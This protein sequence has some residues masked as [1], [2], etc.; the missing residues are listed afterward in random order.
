MSIT[1][2]SLISLEHS[3]IQTNNTSGTYCVKLDNIE[4]FEI[5]D[6]EYPCTLSN[7][8][9]GLFA[10]NSNNIKLHYCEI[11]NMSNFGV[12]IQGESSSTFGE[13]LEVFECNIHDIGHDA[14]IVNYFD[15]IGIENTDIWNSEL[16]IKISGYILS[17]EFSDNINIKNCN[18][19][20][21]TSEWFHGIALANFDMQNCTLTSLGGTFSSVANNPTYNSY[22]KIRDCEFDNITS[23][24]LHDTK[25]LEFKHNK[26][27]DIDC[28]EIST[29]LGKICL[30]A[31]NCGETKLIQNEFESIAT[32]ID[33]TMIRMNHCPNSLISNNNIIST[34]GDEIGVDIHNSNETEVENNF[35]ENPQ[36]GIVLNDDK[37]YIHHN[38]LKNCSITSLEIDSD[39]Y[40]DI[41]HNSIYNE[42]N[43]S[44][45]T[46]VTALTSS[47][48]CTT[49]IKNNIFYLANDLGKLYKFRNYF[50]INTDYNYCNTEFQ[51]FIALS[52]QM[53]ITCHVWGDSLNPQPGD[54]RHTGNGVNSI[55]TSQQFPFNNVVNNDFSLASNA[56]DCINKGVYLEDYNEDFNGSYFPSGCS[57]CTTGIDI[58]AIEYY[59]PSLTSWSQSD[60]PTGWYYATDDI[61]N[62]H[63]H[64]KKGNIYH[65][66][67]LVN[68]RGANLYSLSSTD[69]SFLKLNEWGIDQILSEAIDMG[70]NTI[71]LCYNPDLIK[72]E[73]DLA[74]TSETIPANN[75]TKSKPGNDIFF[76]EN[77]DR[78]TMY[79]ALQAI[80]DRCDYWNLNV[81]LDHHVLE[82]GAGLWYTSTFT[83]IDYLKTLFFV[84]ENF[85]Q[86]N[87]IGID[88]I[89]E[90]TL[91]VW[92]GKGLENDFRRFAQK[93]GKGIRAINPNWLIFVEG[94]QYHGDAAK[95]S[96][97]NNTFSYDPTDQSL[98]PCSNNSPCNWPVSETGSSEQLST[99]GTYPVEHNAIPDYKLVFSPHT[100][101]WQY[102]YVK[103]HFSNQI[104]ADNYEYVTDLNNYRWGYLAEENAVIVGE[105]GAP[106][107]SANGGT[108]PLPMAYS[109]EWFQYFIK[110]MA[111]KKLPGSFYWALN[112]NTGTNIGGS[113]AYYGL[114]TDPNWTVQNSEIVKEYS[115]MFGRVKKPIVSANGGTLYSPRDFTEYTFP[116]NCCTTATNI[117]VEHVSHWTGVSTDSLPKLSG[118]RSVLHEFIIKAKDGTTDLQNTDNPFTIKIGVTENE[119]GNNKSESDINVYKYNE[120]SESWEIFIDYN[121][122]TYLYDNGRQTHDYTFSTSDFGIYALA[123]EWD[124][125]TI[126]L[127]SGWN[128][129]STFIIANEPNIEDMFANIVNDLE[130]IKTF[131]GDVYWP[132]QGVNNIGNWNLI[133][134]YQVLM[135]NANSLTTYGIKCS[136]QYTP[137][138]L[139]VGWSIIAY[140]LD[141]AYD[142]EAVFA[143]IVGNIGVQDGIELVKDVTGKV[144][145]PWFSLNLIGDLLPGQ[146]YQIKMHEEVDFT[147]PILSQGNKSD[148]I[149]YVHKNYTNDIYL[150]PDNFM[151]IGI[152]LQSWDTP[153][154]IGDEIA[155][156]GESG[157]LV[158]KSIFLGNFSA[159]TIHGDD[160]YTPNVIENLAD[161]EEFTIEI[162]SATKNTTKQYKFEHWD[163]GD[164]F[165]ETKQIAIVSQDETEEH[166]D[167]ENF[168]IKVFPNPSDGIMKIAV[169][170]DYDCNASVSIV[171]ILGKTVY[172]S[173]IGIVKGQQDHSLDLSHLPSGSYTLFIAT[174]RV[175]SHETIVINK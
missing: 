145:W 110:Y 141:D 19:H 94:V 57:S 71:R 30:Y 37:G 69:F 117:N 24:Q 15:N 90:P 136:P 22:F 100:Y 11:S 70:I 164:R 132:G 147:Y 74:S 35:I 158:G 168:Q 52:D 41:Y 120:N 14:L 68:I 148:N 47:T 54:Y 101:Q 103:D 58:G 105:F 109:E 161:G 17:L 46:G 130:Q 33:G 96:E 171:D 118:H 123:T 93:A 95:E 175:I 79:E 173:E 59:A 81:L 102:N 134:G 119:L 2:S 12:K 27:T 53:P 111:E 13:N 151:I 156:F 8:E 83:E 167:S 146:G 150:N 66:G 28:E 121:N 124:Q 159:I 89:N 55:G 104:I 16:A 78:I 48:N 9:N 140:L 34:N 133:E 64:H 170:S 108:L 84:A 131:D 72:D 135:N 5:L 154:Q 29:S 20:D 128:M 45:Y 67:E 137:I 80:V 138:H 43:S 86:S 61:V 44:N 126:S 50:L 51:N 99:Y 23:F 107:A 113:S 106:Y 97:E 42:G 115:V 26:L 139:P 87:I 143:D 114:L 77:D 3:D 4:Y 32:S 142:A 91:A 56:T 152:P 49:N 39:A 92:D 162:W 73:M 1:N 60:T 62:T 18:I 125:Q 75:V 165:F 166:I 153:P 65:N 129:I 63:P 38:I 174:D 149:H 116:S 155:A 127:N 76:D 7:A 88:L 157:Q 160:Y 112:G 98:G 169:K 31:K 172:S 10:D 36:K 163:S 85:Q 40:A 82:E 122:L 25:E 144:Y 21:I 6:P